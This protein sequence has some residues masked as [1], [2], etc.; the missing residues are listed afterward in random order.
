LI[1]QDL[2]PKGVQTLFSILQK[3]GAS[4]D[5]DNNCR[6]MHDPKTISTLGTRRVNPIFMK[7][8]WN[9]TR[10]AILSV[11]TT[12]CST[13]ALATCPN[14]KKDSVSTNVKP[15]TLKGGESAELQVLNMQCGRCAAKVRKALREDL[16]FEQV[17]VDLDA[18]KATLAC[19]AGQNCDLA[20]AIKTLNEMGYATT[21]L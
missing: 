13:Q 3:S 10:L 5:P 9:F 12:A 15:A 18:K 2:R 8:F 14:T 1:F 20:R 4:Q 21:R 11:V 17:N 19:P 6:P 16:K 7:S